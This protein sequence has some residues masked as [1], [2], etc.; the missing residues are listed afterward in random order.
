MRQPRRN[1]LQYTLFGILAGLLLIIIST[2]T[3]TLYVLQLP[4]TIR[5]LLSVQSTTPL[6]WII[7]TSPIFLAFMA[8]FAGYRQ[9]QVADLTDTYQDQL[10]KQTQLSMQLETATEEL[11]MRVAERTQAIDRRSTYLNR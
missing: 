11:E 10:Q 1:T 2:L 9:D 5:N 7:D 3:Q 8:G 4:F 6:L